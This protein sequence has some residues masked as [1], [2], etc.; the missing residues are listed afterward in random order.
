MLKIIAIPVV[1]A[2]AGVLLYAATRPDTFR[3]ARTTSIK[4]APDRIF[5]LINDLHRFNAWNPYEKKDPDIKGRYSGPDSGKGAQYAFEGNNEVGMGSLEIT[6]SEPPGR[7]AMRLRMTAP[8]KADNQIEFTLEPEGDVTH[9][10]WAMQGRSPYLAKLIGLVVNMDRMIGR[11]FE[12]GLANLKG[13][14]EK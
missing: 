7:V 8:M 2:V 14:V 9:V 13:I 4:A 6:D 3:V 10:T 11:D 1:V 12:A 5:P